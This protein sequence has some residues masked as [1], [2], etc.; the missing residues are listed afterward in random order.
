MVRS[1]ARNL[2]TLAKKTNMLADV[3]GEMEGTS[4]KTFDDYVGAL[5]RLFVGE[6]VEAWSPAIRSATVIRQGRKRCFADPSIAVAALGASPRDLEL[7]LKTF[8][9][10]YECM[11]IRDLKVY[12]QALGGM[13]SHYHDRYGL[14]ADAVLHLADGRY[15]L[16]ECKLGSRDVEDGAGHLLTLR[17]LIR[18]RNERERREVLRLPSL[19]IVLSGGKM[20]YA[21]EDGVKVIPLG[22]LRD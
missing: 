18:E 19:L 14:E 2:C 5:E 1:Y 6:D 20:A 15:A 4:M 13:L 12:S 7:D 3:C 21:R 10:V 11:C 17:D 16:V 22:C 8:G 9:F